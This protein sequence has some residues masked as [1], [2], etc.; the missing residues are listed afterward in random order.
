MDHDP[1]SSLAF[2]NLGVV[3]GNNRYFLQLQVEKKPPVI[4]LPGPDWYDMRHKIAGLVILAHGDRQHTHISGF[5]PN[6][7]GTNGFEEVF[8]EM[9]YVVLRLH[10]LLLWKM[11][12]FI[13][14]C[15]SLLAF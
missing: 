8:D 11:E 3:D 15:Q 6:G 7:V 5:V 2:R 1:D 12:T 14:I 9:L 4:L 10:I 13:Y